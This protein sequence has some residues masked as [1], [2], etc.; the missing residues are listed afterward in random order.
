MT[1]IDMNK[2]ERIYKSFL[3]A[4]TNE[5]EITNMQGEVMMRAFLWTSSAREIE[6]ELYQMFLHKEITGAEHTYLFG[7]ICRS[8]LNNAEGDFFRI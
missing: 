8:A 2:C 5:Q 4:H 1:N 7:M 6:V 3:E